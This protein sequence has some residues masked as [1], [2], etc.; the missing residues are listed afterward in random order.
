MT[1]LNR[2][3]F[4]NDADYFDKCLK[5]FYLPL[6]ESCIDFI[7]LC[8]WTYDPRRKDSKKIPFF[9]YE[10]Q[11]E[12]IFWL[13]ERYKLKENGIV[14]K[15]RDVGASWCF[16]AFSIWMLLFQ[17]GSAIGFYSYKSDAVD[18]KG[19][20]DSLMEKA[21]FIIDNLPGSIKLALQQSYMLIKNGDSSISGLSGEQPRGGRKSMLFKDESAFYE[22]PEIIE[23]A[24]SETSDCII[25]IS[26]HAGTDT[27][28]FNKIQSGSTPTFI[29][30]WWQNPIH[31]QEWYDK[32][33]EKALSEGL[34]HI[35][36]REINRN[37]QASVESVVINPSWVISARTHDKKIYGKKILG[38]DTADDGTDAKAIVFVNGNVV[39][40]ISQWIEGDIGDASEKA[41]KKAIELGADE[42]HYDSIGIGAGA[43]IRLKQLIEGQQSKIQL[44]GW[45]AGSGVIRPDESDF[46][47]QPNKMLFENAKSQA[48]WKVREEFI[49]TYRYIN[50]KDHDPSKIIFIEDMKDNQYF[51]KFIN[52]LS[53]PQHK[54]SA[55]GKII[56]DKKAG[57]KSP[58][59]CFVKGTLILTPKGNTPIEELKIGD[60]VITP[61]GKRK[62]LNIIKSES[63]VIEN[64][65]L[66]GTPT[67]KIFTRTGIKDLIKCS[68][69]DIIK[70]SAYQLLSWRFLWII[71]K[72]LTG[73]SIGFYK[74][75][76]IISQGMVNKKTIENY[77]MS[78]YGK[79]KIIKAYLKA[80]VFIILMEIP[81]I[82]I[83]K[84]LCLWQKINTCNI[85]QKKRIKIKNITIKILN[86][87]KKLD[88][89]QMNREKKYRMKNGL[90][91]GK[92]HGLIKQFMKKTAVLN[93][94]KKTIKKILKNHNQNIDNQESII[95]NV[96]GA[97]K[98][99][100]QKVILLD[101]V[102]YHARQQEIIM[103]EVINISVEHDTCY[104]ANEILVKN[105]EAYIIARAEKYLEISIWDIPL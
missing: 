84:I 64:I 30:D 93:V 37:P 71:I 65:G 53:Q 60:Y 105:C 73:K 67:H 8:V 54:L 20:M 51:N 62:I 49:Q 21:R 46:N 69:R 40:Y 9:L 75:V 2:L 1:Y 41:Y 96:N 19:E 81:S 39:Q 88:F 87:L 10:R 50:N 92:N 103:Q 4:E 56:I 15:C 61:F 23:G 33:K 86:I 55:S 27:V 43:K 95:K 31:T 76:N 104:Y 32:K 35:F 57:K 6:P 72:N 13:W 29:F 101:S 38:F 36:E 90:K 34:M 25:D 3:K 22:H 68:T 45:N 17:K 63:V 94:G 80:I 85:I 98:N 97:R 79:K 11:N 18:K 59:L 14:D 100:N 91:S 77:Y 78:Q 52:E 58:N 70:A 66:K 89:W 44:I 99:L 83:L 42:I 24:L 7:N 26:T 28:F 5:S 12:F 74:A 47:D 48:Y 102:H 82:I 16:V